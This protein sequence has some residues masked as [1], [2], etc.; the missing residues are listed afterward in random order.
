[1]HAAFPAADSPVAASWQPM[2]SAERRV[3]GV[4]VEKAKTTP[5]NYPLSLN[6]VRTGCN[7]KN[8]RAP[9]MQ[10]EDEQVEASLDELRRAGAVTVIEGSGRVDKYRHRAYEWLGV[11][12]VE[13]AV[14]AELLLR[15]AQTIGELRAR[16]AR[17][18]PIKDLVALRPVLDSLEAKRLI[19]YLTPSGRGAVLTHALY[20]DRELDKLRRDTAVAA[21]VGD[22]ELEDDGAADANTGLTDADDVMAELGQ[23]REELDAVKRDFAAARTDFAS[24]AAQLR[25]ELDEL[26]RQLGN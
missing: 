4:L 2:G 13:L 1:M 3:L 21:P 16:A 14:M 12:K 26:N 10:L 22:A 7:Q 15:G 8:N 5:E 23:L 25:R 18:E 24:T 17:M 19:V 11:E 9:V 20:Q 6:A